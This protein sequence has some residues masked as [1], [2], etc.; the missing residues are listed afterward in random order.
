LLRPDIPVELAAVLERMMAKDPDERYQVPAEVVEAV[1]PLCSGANLARLFAWEDL[2]TCSMAVAPPAP[3]RKRSRGSWWLVRRRA[4]VAVALGLAILATAAAVWN[5]MSASKPAEIVDRPEVAVQQAILFVRRNGDDN[6]IEK[7]T[8]TDRHDETGIALRPLGP[9]DDFKLH[10]EFNRPADWCL[11]WLDTK[12]QVQITARSECAEKVVDYPLGNHR[13]VRVD[14]HDPAGIHLLLLLTSDRPPRE[15]AGDI[16]HCL[17]DIGPPPRVELGKDTPVG[18]T[19]G[20]GSVQTTTA[21]L[22]SA[23]FQR[24]ERQ[25]PSTVHW[26][27]RLY[28]PT[29]R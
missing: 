26:V 21:N 15:I 4:F 6:S 27:H 2:P 7:L 23:Y 14:P 11:V 13:L 20:A 19:R 5:R 1:T 29:Q 24:V 18:I 8:L 22:D 3:P 10:A 16:E 28:L 9:N 12:G 25:L 17:A